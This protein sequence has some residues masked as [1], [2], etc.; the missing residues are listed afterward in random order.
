MFL[1]S[2][3]SFAVF[4]FFIDWFLYAQPEEVTEG[5]ITCQQVGRVSSVILDVLAAQDTGVTGVKEKQGTAH[6]VAGSLTIR[7]IP[8]TVSDAPD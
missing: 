3:I 8:R 5:L 1:H 4:I 6:N 2:Y 7:N